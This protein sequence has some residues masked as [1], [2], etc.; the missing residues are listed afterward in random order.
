MIGGKTKGHNNF[1]DRIIKIEIEYSDDII[2][3]KV[4]L[5]SLQ[6]SISRKQLIHHSFIQ[7]S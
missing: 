7:N 5:E 3:T 4:Q 1:L 2:R 6:S